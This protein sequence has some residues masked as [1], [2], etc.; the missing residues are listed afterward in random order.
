MCLRCSKG[1]YAAAFNNTITLTKAPHGEAKDSILVFVR[2]FDVFIEIER[3]EA[4]KG[5]V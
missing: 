5:L 4:Y 1:Q 3:F 2:I